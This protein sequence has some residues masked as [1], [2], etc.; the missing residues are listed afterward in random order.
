MPLRH[1]FQRTLPASGEVRIGR[2]PERLRS[3]AL[4]AATGHAPSSLGSFERRARDRGLDLSLLWTAENSGGSLLAAVLAVP[5]PGRTASVLFSVGSHPDQIALTGRVLAHAAAELPENG[6]IALLQCLPRPAEESRVRALAAGGFARLARL[7]SMERANAPVRREPVP[8]LPD[9][10]RLEPWDPSDRTT[11]AALLRRTFEGT[12][13]CPGLAEMREDADILDGHVSS[14]DGDTTMWRIARLHGA[15]IGVVLL[16]PCSVTDSVDLVYLGLAPEARGKG[17][18]RL[19]L[20]HGLRLAAEST[21]RTVQLAVDIANTPAMQLYRRAGF[22]ARQQ[23]EAW[24][25]PLSSR[26]TCPQ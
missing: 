10:C 21:A 23:R 19:L 2:A 24:V 5:A 3:E 8:P 22:A 25:R 17:L 9:G 13:D 18:G 6:G 15:P 7:D 4:S 26:R 11:M 20:A 12:L 16:S 1:L 14:G